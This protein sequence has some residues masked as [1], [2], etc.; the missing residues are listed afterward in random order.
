MICLNCANKTLENKKYCSV[1]CARSYAGK[2]G[3]KKTQLV[4]ANM[5][6]KNGKE[7]SRHLKP[8]YTNTEHQ[9]KAASLSRTGID[10]SNIGNSIR[11]QNKFKSEHNNMSRYEFMLWEHPKFQKLNPIRQDYRFHTGRTKG[12]IIMDFSLPQ[13]KLC[14]EIDGWG[15]DPIKDAERDKWLLDNH[16]WTTIRFKNEEIENNIDTAIKELSSKLTSNGAT[17]LGGVGKGCNLVIAKDPSSNS[18]KAKQA[19]DKGV[20]IIS[21]EEAVKRYL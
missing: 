13:Y 14:I 2:I 1:S 9:S 6:K 17:E 10:K 16:G 4:H 5:Y 12:G 7:L 3:G 11:S 15:H 20:E 18:G 19:R 21:L 8:F